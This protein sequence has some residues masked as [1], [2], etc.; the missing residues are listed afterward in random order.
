MKKNRHSLIL[1]LIKEFDVGTQEE[2]LLLLREKGY[3]VTQATVSRDIKE[4]R[5]LK[6]LDKNGVYK[7]TTEKAKDT[8]YTGMLSNLFAG[9]LL[10]VDYAGNICVIKCSPG[11]ANAACAAIDNMNVP[12]VVGT[13]A[14]DDTIFMLCRTEDEAA[15]VAASLIKMI[16]E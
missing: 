11:L 9:S 4:L 1:E 13:I 16:K 3:D 7:Y 8:G 10:N 15:A 6:T 14:G 12:E 2:L 5:L